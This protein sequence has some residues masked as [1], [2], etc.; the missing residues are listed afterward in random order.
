VV[1]RATIF[2]EKRR[3]GWCPGTDQWVREQVA[4]FRSKEVLVK[5][6]LDPARERVEFQELFAGTAETR[7]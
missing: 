4:N 7:G 3:D 6:W 2:V 5:Q 1:T